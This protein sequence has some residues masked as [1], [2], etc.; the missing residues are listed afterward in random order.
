[1]HLFLFVLERGNVT[2]AAVLIAKGSSLFGLDYHFSAVHEFKS[3][4]DTVTLHVMDGERPAEN[5]ALVARGAANEI[6]VCLPI[7]PPCKS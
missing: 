1:M 4:D 2:A 7:P 6:M 5:D 3:I